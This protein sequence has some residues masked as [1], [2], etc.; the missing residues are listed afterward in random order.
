VLSLVVSKNGAK[1]RLA[2]SFAERKKPEGNG[3]CQGKSNAF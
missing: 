2:D 3:S 1:R